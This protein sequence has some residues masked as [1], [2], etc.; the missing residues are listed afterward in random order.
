MS[1]PWG[2]EP[3]RFAVEE[4]LDHPVLMVVKSPNSHAPTRA[5][6]VPSELGQKEAARRPE[7]LRNAYDE[8]GRT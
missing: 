3:H 1:I 8:R 4:P 7:E 5:G 2:S 6:M